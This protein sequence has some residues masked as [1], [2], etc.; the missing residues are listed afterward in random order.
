M[1]GP[2]YALDRQ[3]ILREVADREGQA[4]V[5]QHRD[6]LEAQLDYLESLG[7]VRT[8]EEVKAR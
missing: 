3:R 5:D 4:F 6:L 8:D 7:G 1:T 2:T